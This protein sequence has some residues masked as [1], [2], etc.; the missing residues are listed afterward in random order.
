MRTF[1]SIALLA[2][3]LAAQDCNQNGVP[4]AQDI[5]QQDSN[6]CDASGIP[7]ECEYA[8]LW[9]FQDFD[10]NGALPAGV[11]ETTTGLW[12][13]TSACRPAGGGATGEFMYFGQ[14]A[15]CNFD[16]GATAQGLYVLRDLA[17]PVD[18][19]ILLSYWSY[20]AGE[21]GGA[22]DCDTVM[23]VDGAFMGV[24]SGPVLDDYCDEPP[25]PP[26][27]RYRTVDLAAFAGQTVDLYWGF[28][29]DDQLFNFDFG[30]GIDDIRIWT[31]TDVSGNGVPDLCERISVTYCSSNPNSTG[32]TAGL[33]ALGSAVVADEDLFLRTVFVPQNEFGYYLM[34]LTQASVNLPPPSGGILCLGSPFIRFRQNVL[35]S[36]SIGELRMRIDFQ[37]LP[38]QTVFMPGD[39]WNLQAWFRDGGSSNTSRAVTVSFQ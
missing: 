21:S 33:A 9:L 10:G 16:T 30:W 3:P 8:S 11:S 39:T 19:A 22:V 17:L 18:S 28:N 5:A 27:W 20:Y 12:H 34:S 4:D 35:N 6:D 7:D 32:Q 25:I 15:T 36:G 2:A 13:E 37:D 38:Q 24:L 26:N 31:A 29:S 23:I 14:D 1:V